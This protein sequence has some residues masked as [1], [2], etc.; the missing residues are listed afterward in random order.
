M[1]TS[2]D[3]LAFAQRRARVKAIFALA[4]APIP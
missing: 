3:W 2:T 4:S 1:D